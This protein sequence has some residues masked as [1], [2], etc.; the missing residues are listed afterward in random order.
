MAGPVDVYASLAIVAGRMIIRWAC[1]SGAVTA[2]ACITNDIATAA[3]FL[4]MDSLLV[5]AQDP[6]KS[7]SS[8]TSFRAPD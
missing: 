7:L 3:S 5:T 2:A 6:V 8:S 1:S 4:T